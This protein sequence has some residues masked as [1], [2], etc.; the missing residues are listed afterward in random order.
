MDI[1]TD[2]L[3]DGEIE[4]RLKKNVRINGPANSWKHIREQRKQSQ[5]SILEAL[6]S[7]MCWNPGY[8]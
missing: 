7:H 3:T 1:V 6:S 2:C 5:E 8:E 4:R